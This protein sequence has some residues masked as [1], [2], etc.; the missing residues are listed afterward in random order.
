M[1]RVKRL[2]YPGGF[3]HIYNRGLNRDRVFIQSRDYEKLLQKLSEV[4]SEGDWVVYAYCLMPNHYHF[5]IEENRMA[6]AKLMGRVFTSY[7]VYF[8]TKYKKHGPVFEDRFKSKLIQKDSYFQQVSRY[9]H[10]NP[11]EARLVSVPLEY[12]YSSLVEYA[13]RSGRNII[14]LAKVT[15]LLG[16]RKSRISEYLKF[17]QAGIKTDLSE[18]DPFVNKNDVIGNSTFASH[19]KMA[20][21]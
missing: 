12:P 17:V 18:F 21:F 16:E 2:T 3:Y 1:P 10:L 9:I 19:R 13:G 6:I 8:N 5:L 4:L 7:A 11:V 20:R 15:A 14:S